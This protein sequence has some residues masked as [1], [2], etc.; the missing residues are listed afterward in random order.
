[1]DEEQIRLKE[2]YFDEITN[3]PLAFTRR[4]KQVA[5]EAVDAWR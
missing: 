3:Q 1:M 2:P 4:V 5:I